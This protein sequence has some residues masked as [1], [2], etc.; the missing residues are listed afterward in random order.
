MISNEV[1]KFLETPMQR[2]LVQYRTGNGW[3]WALTW[4]PKSTHNKWLV[5]DACKTL[6][7]VV[8]KYNKEMEKEGRK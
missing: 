3:R 5:V 4:K 8:V 2:D 1:E 7:E 6:E